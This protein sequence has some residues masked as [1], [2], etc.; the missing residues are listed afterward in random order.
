MKGMAEEEEYMHLIFEP[1][2]FLVGSGHLS[3]YEFSR[4]LKGY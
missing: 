3:K 1:H 4:L 2:G